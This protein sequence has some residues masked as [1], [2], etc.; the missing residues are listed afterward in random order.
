MGL[1]PDRL[2]PNIHIFISF[3]SLHG[4]LKSDTSAVTNTVAFPRY[5]TSCL[6]S[7]VSIS[8]HDATTH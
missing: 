2:I 1:F 8:L 4:K 6:H 5:T 7:E 3:P